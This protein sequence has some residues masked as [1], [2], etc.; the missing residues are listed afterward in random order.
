MKMNQ[1]EISSELWRL[2]RIRRE[3]IAHLMEEFDK[4]HY[5]KK[6]ELRQKCGAIGHNWRFSHIGPVG[7]AWLHCS[8]CGEYRAED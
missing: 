3:K 7:N 2:D 4:E 1:P 8:V 6:K 5:A